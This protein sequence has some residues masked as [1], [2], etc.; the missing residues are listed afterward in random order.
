MLYHFHLAI[1][2]RWWG[3]YIAPR[4]T[5]LSRIWGAYVPDR[6]TALRQ[7]GGILKILKVIEWLTSLSLY[8]DS[9]F[10]AFSTEVLAWPNRGTIV[11]VLLVPP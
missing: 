3:Y 2:V 1:G 6:E 7:C 9:Q 4:G 11:V 10:S 8:H 5:E